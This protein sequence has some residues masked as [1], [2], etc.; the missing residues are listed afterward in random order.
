MILKNKP[1][2]N[3]AI[4]DGAVPDE[5]HMKYMFNKHR[6]RIMLHAAGR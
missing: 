1:G 5:K 3:R 6:P 4:E 2:E